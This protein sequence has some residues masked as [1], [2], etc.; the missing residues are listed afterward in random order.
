MR[1]AIIAILVL[2]VSA[3]TVQ[4][5]EQIGRSVKG[6]EKGSCSITCRKTSCSISCPTTVKPVPYCYCW[7]YITN[8]SMPNPN[9]YAR[10][11]CQQN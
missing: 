7:S 8:P 2:G 5:A 3:M 4:A 10:C 1:K 6:R 9:D 11:L